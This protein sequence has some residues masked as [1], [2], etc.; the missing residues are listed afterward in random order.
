MQIKNRGDEVF[1][2]TNNILI[3]LTSLSNSS[4]GKAV[5]A[6][7][8]NSIGNPISETLDVWSILFENIPE[9]FLGTSK[10]ISDEEKA[11]LTTL[12]LYA[13]H[14]QGVSHSVL[15]QKDK[16]FNNLGYS[17]RKL[18]TED[19]RVAMDRRF[20]AMITSSTFEELSY[21]LRQLVKLLKSKSSEVRV[22]YAKLSE[23]LYW[24]LRGY[25]ENVRLN[26][27]REY[28]KQNYRGEKENGK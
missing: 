21:R 15:M 6:N 23:D 3:K 25:D 7:L 12:Q 11:I 4:S 8:R 1:V 18:R 22:D 19:N 26:W 24:F 20:N 16:K 10:E 13:M 27:A 28:Y 5:L 14:Q 17:L 9:S 2:T